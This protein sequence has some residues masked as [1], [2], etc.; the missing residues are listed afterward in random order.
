MNL[1]DLG[2]SLVGVGGGYRSKLG[3]V[4][5]KMVRAISR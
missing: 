5:M 3:M 1:P 4:V 2:F